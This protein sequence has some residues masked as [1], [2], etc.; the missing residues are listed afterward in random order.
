[1]SAQKQKR[2]L[3]SR[4]S[5]EFHARKML[6]F[7]LEFNGHFQPHAG[8]S[9]D[10]GSWQSAGRSPW[11][12]RS[13]LKAWSG[14]ALD[15][16]FANYEYLFDP[17][18]QLTQEIINGES[19]NYGYDGLGQ[20][21]GADR[22][23]GTD[24][25]FAFDANGN[26]TGNGYIVGPNNQIL[27]DGTFNYAYDNEGNMVRKTE[28]ATGN[29]TEYTWDHRNRLVRV[30]ERSAGGI[31]L[32][33]S[34]YTYDVF[35]RR[36]AKS[37]DWDGAGPQPAERTL[38]IYDRVNTWADFNEAGDLIARYLYGNKI[39]EL[40][41]RLWPG[42][43]TSWYLTDHLGT[44]RDLVNALG[45]LVNH[46]DFDSF[47]RILAQTNA[48]FSDRFLFTGR[49]FDSTTGLYFFRAR[50]IDAILGRFITQDP[51]GLEGDLNLYRYVI[52]SPLNLTDPSGKLITERVKF[53][54]IV[55]FN[56]VL[57]CSVFATLATVAVGLAPPGFGGWRGVGLM[58]GFWFILCMNLYGPLPKPPGGGL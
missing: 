10:Q 14:D 49:E 51:I 50:Y 34:N 42:E 12:A 20:L 11:P 45:Q 9:F 16:F 13:R 22:A 31:I 38:F 26:R 30:T 44:V 40:L 28:I 23:T 41:A 37:V 48:L 7:A 25:A 21:I 58:W 8:L 52:N 27:S 53:Y 6:A 55:I 19:S 33:E 29:I 43:G 24:E 3:I 56:R 15:A 1:M 5:C 18:G 54:A 39:D 2:G 17:A 36:I 32:K 46:I 47:G 35:D 4:H 57:S